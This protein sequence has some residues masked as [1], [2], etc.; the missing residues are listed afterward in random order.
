MIVKKNKRK[1]EGVLITF[2]HYNK[3]PKATNFIKKA[4]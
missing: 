2:C 1:M 4:G 3:I